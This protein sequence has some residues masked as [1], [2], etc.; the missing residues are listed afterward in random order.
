MIV[1]TLCGIP[2]WLYLIA[3][4]LLDPQDSISEVLLFGIGLWALGG[5][6]LIL[7]LTWLIIILSIWT[8]ASRWSSRGF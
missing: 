6:Q 5:L 1:T 2:T 7:L 3:R 4:W 8:G